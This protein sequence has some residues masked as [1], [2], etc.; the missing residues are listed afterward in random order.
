MSSRTAR[1][2][3]TVPS[4]SVNFPISSAACR[5]SLALRVSV[6]RSWRIARPTRRR[7]RRV[8]SDASPRR[9]STSTR[10]AS[11]SSLSESTSIRKFSD[12]GSSRRS[13]SRS[14]SSLRVESLTGSTAL[15]AWI[16]PSTEALLN[17]PR[18]VC[19]AARPATCVRL[20]QPAVAECGQPSWTGAVQASAVPRQPRFGRRPLALRQQHRLSRP[21]RV[22]EV[23]RHAR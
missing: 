7:R 17:I 11:G 14:T 10:T 4:T 1:S 20:W 8:A 18:P 15:N 3:S 16:R 12:R 2:A 13:K 5:R 22:R 19:R 23:T 6:R 21:L 9:V